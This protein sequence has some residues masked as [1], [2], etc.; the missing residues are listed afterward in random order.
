MLAAAFFVTLQFAIVRIA[1]RYIIFFAFIRCDSYS[2][3]PPD[4]CN[5]SPKMLLFNYHDSIA[6]TLGRLEIF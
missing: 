6:I 3:H 1:V 5:R 4:H 2:H